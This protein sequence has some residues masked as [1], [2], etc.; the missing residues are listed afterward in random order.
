VKKK[1]LIITGSRADFGKLKTVI[2]KLKK[3]K[4][5]KIYIVATGMHLL[6]KYGYTYV[7][8]IK[9][10]GKKL[11]KFRNQKENDDL[12]KILINTV[13]KLL[14]IVNKI[15]PDLIIYHGDRIETLAAALVGSLNHIL[16]AHIEGGE[17]SGTIDDTIRHAVTKLS[18]LHFVGNKKAAQRVIKMGENENKVFVIGSPDMDVLFKSNIKIKSTKNRYNIKFNDYAILIWHPVTSEIKHLR[19]NTNKLLKFAKNSI[20]NFVI[21][22]PNNDPGSQIIIDIFNKYKNLKKFRFIKSMRFE[23]FISLLK[24]AK[25]IIGNSSAGIYEAPPL[26]IPTINIGSRQNNRFINRNILNLDI[27]NLNYKKINE[28]CKKFKPTSYS[29][30]GKGKSANLFLKILNKKNFWLTSKQKFFYEKN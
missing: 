1:L 9:F 20:D 19:H 25:Y 23:N 18:H 24:N 12:N 28:F 2:S 13:E 17:V 8:V 6:R 30:Y 29:N 11:I 4:K 5:F 21:I 16:T 15:K 3:N 7:E 27:R 26:K 10:F 22:F 14:N